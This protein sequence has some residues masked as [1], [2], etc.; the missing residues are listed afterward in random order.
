MGRDKAKIKNWKEW[1]RLQA[2]E[3]KE[4]GW[5]HQEIAEALNVSKAAIS[6]CAL[7]PVAPR[8]HA[9]PMRAPTG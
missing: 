1:R 7:A 6:Q 2:I 8:V 3:L 4:L 5:S 9:R